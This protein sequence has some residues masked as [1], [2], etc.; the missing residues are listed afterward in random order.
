[1]SWSIEPW[2]ASEPLEVQ[3]PGK[4]GRE[5]AAWAGW[6]VE[7][8]DYLA[9]TDSQRPERYPNQAHRTVDL[10]HAR[11]ATVDA[12]TAIDLCAA[13]LGRMH[14]GYPRKGWEMKYGEAKDDA[15]LRKQPACKQWI[16][17]VKGDAKYAE[18][19]E[20]RNAL[21]HSTAVRR[22]DVKVPPVVV[23]AVRGQSRIVGGPGPQI[24]RVRL[25]VSNPT[26]EF[27][28]EKLVPQCRDLARR[29]VGA[30]LSAA[31]RL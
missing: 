27:A 20:L 24:S 21:V 17:S 29:H 25:H 12:I 31:A 10:S 19:L 28:V 22:I 30:F 26:R 7:G 4:G 8:L 3:F 11:W 13:A 16:D 23:Q 1:V 9:G 15:R 5:L 6:T 2:D 14:C 18:V